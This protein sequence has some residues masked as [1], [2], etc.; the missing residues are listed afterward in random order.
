MNKEDKIWLKSK[1][2]SLQAIADMN[3]ETSTEW[4]LKNFINEIEERV[5]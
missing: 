3:K 5:E 4:Y 1:K 2:A